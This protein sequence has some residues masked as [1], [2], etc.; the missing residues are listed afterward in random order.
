MQAVIL[1]G[2]KGTRLK[3][4]TTVLPKPLMPVGDYPI[5][6]IVVRQLARRGFDRIIL[7]VGYHYEL[8][9]AFFQDGARWG[10]TIEYSLEEHP[11]GTIGPLGLIRSLDDNFL[12]MNG[13]TLTDLDYRE[14]YDRH[15]REKHTMTITTQTRKV[16]VD[17]GVITCDDGTLS[18]YAEKP[19]LSYKV[20]IGVQVFSRKIMEYIPAKQHFDFPD[21]VHEMLRRGIPIH[22]QPYDGY[23]L[24]IGR[25]DD[26]QLAVEYF[27][28]NGK[29]FL[30]E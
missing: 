5:L 23:A 18:H 24:D 15:V 16:K 19:E 1:A 12:I 8:F 3:P 7:A 21:L 28:K 22:C 25:P 29:Q 11:L 27:C 13:D 26:Y 2:G 20:A 9:Q 4:Y 6:E 14:L 17:Y 10:V 30:G